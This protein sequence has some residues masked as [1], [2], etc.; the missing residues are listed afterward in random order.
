MLS[1][2]NRRNH[3]VALGT[4]VV[5]VGLLSG[6]ATPYK[7]LSGRYGFD[8]FRI[9]EDVFQVSFAANA[10]TP[11]S[12]VSRYVLRR[13]SEVTLLHG[14]THFVPLY[15]EDQTLV[16]SLNTATGSSTTHI[17]GSGSMAWTHGSASGL[18]IPFRMPAISVRIRCF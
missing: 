9:T 4:T 8:D 1:Q 11:P 14:F 16:G 6:C 13:A 12:T 15:E 18:N 5:S 7:M 17:G 2:R 3:L 10:K